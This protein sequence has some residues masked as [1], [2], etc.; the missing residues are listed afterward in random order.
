MSEQPPTTALVKAYQSEPPY[1][2]ARQ[3]FFDYATLADI[4]RATGVTVKVIKKWRSDEGW[5]LEREDDT[6]GLLES[7]FGSRK[8]TIAK[9]I[10]TAP[11]IL[12]R[13]LQHLATRVDPITLD[14]AVKVSAI[15]ANL[16]KISRLD[17]DKATDNI[18]IHAKIQMTADE[19]RKVILSD[20]FMAGEVVPDASSEDV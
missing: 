16:D 1:I 7:S 5:E 11:E 18:N 15:I 4:S 6:R 20:P 9:I 17:N 14:E 12:H 19:I 3:L 8:V 2:L 10:K 13:G